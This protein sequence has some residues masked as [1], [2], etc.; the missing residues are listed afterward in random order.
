M[1]SG[2]ANSEYSTLENP[3]IVQ[4]TTDA[5]PKT[6]EAAKNTKR[7]VLKKSKEQRNFTIA[8]AEAKRLKIHLDSERTQYEKTDHYKLELTNIIDHQLGLAAAA[9]K[10]VDHYEGKIKKQTGQSEP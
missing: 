8:N 6:P 4:E 10:R 5:V 1:F 7:Q 3:Y 9:K 2:V